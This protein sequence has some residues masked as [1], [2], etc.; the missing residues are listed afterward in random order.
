[1]GSIISVHGY[2]VR[3]W[4]G[5]ALTL[6]RSFAVEGPRWDLEIDHTVIHHDQDGYCNTPRVNSP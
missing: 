4:K 5:V 6:Y 1:M 3:F 2:P